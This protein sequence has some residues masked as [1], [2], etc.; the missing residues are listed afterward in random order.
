MAVSAPG[1]E[2]PPDEPGARLDRAR[3]RI[4]IVLGPLL[5]LALWLA[6]L[7]MAEA[8]FPREAQRLAAV[9]A[10]VVVF[11]IG[12]PIPV[13]VTA[14]LGPTLALLIGAVPFDPKRPDEAIRTAYSKFGDPILMMFIGGFFIA[15]A[16]TVHGLDRRFAMR[17]LSTR[18]FGAS[19]RNMVVGL[20]VCAALLSMWVS[21]TATTALLLPIASGM[22]ALTR[23][24]GSKPGRVDALCMLMIPF[25][26]TVGG[27][28]TPVGTAPN[29]IGLGHIRK[30]GLDISFLHWMQLTLPLCLA[31]LVC[32]AILLTRELPADGA[33]LSAH[34]RAEHARL[35]PWK[36][37]EVVT[38]A[39]FGLAVTL[40]IVSGLAQLDEKGALNQWFKAHL[41]ESVIALVAASL[42]FVVP[43]AP[44]RATLT[45]REATRIDW[46]TLLLLGGGLSLG[47]M[48]KT[49]GLADVVGRG[50]V[51]SLG[52]DTLWGLTAVASILAI[53]LS[54]LTSNTAT[55]SLLVPVVIAI[56]QS[57]GV[58]PLPPALAATFACSFGFML[59]VSTP[60]NALAYGTGKIPIALMVSRGLVFDILG[61]I[62]I[63]VGLRLMA[64][65]LGG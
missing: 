17:I 45:W 33:D 31:M 47:D 34:A 27:L 12:E 44:G 52:I 59:P 51:T 62:I 54:E 10:L 64:P 23:P 13:A 56:A 26:A 53:G 20:G 3:G 6:P 46:G 5:F 1:V 29:L 37:G 40:W 9:M 21:N 36:Q 42:L 57:A 32:L 41:P 49:T 35:G 14:L 28:G 48:M 19:P 43:S 8:A 25:A 30:L 50:V 2:D 24:E 22:L 65:W 55:V 60:P 4:A 61:A 58:S 15:E 16:M 11:W 7:P 18:V 63:V 38:A 39:S